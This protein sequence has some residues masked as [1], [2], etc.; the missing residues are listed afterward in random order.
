[1]HSHLKL[2]FYYELAKVV[3]VF[4]K[5]RSAH[6]ERAQN[7]Y[8]RSG[9]GTPTSC[10]DKLWLVAVVWIHI[11]VVNEQH[12]AG[13]GY[14][15]CWFVSDVQSNL[16]FVKQT[17]FPL[18]ADFSQISWAWSQIFSFAN[19]TVNTVKNRLAENTAHHF[20]KQQKS[21][22]D[23]CKI[24]IVLDFQLSRWDL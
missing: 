22:I 4:K 15:W 9:P 2:K 19:S 16:M 12:L 24:K 10:F 7:S 11:F 5:W 17:F 21:R 23:T 8:E 1:M 20:Y 13:W 14:M 18:P 6:H 3:C